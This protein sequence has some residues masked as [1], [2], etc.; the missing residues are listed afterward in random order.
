MWSIC[1]SQTSLCLEKGLEGVEV[2][3]GGCWAV[4]GGGNGRLDHPD[5]GS[6]DGRKGLNSETLHPTEA[7]LSL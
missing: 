5:G 4:Q 7:M 6:M 2:D 3:A 1:I